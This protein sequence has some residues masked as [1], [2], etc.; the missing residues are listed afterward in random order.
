MTQASAPKPRIVPKPSKSFTAS[1]AESSTPLLEEL[2]TNTN[3]PKFVLYSTIPVSRNTCLITSLKIESARSFPSP[4]ELLR[5]LR[6]G[7]GNAL[8]TSFEKSII[9]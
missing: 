4:I 1:N 3:L 9:H 2:E 8:R 6:T 5:S 7:E